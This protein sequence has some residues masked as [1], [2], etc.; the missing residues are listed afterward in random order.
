MRTN[1]LRDTETRLKCFPSHT[2]CLARNMAYAVP[3]RQKFVYGL[4]ARG[5][6][7]IAYTVWGK[8]TAARTAASAASHSLVIR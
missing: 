7:N 1:I 5:F 2:A 6:H 4:S 8:A 3:M